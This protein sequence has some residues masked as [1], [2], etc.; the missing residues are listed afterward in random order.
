MAIHVCSQCGHREPI[1]GSDGG[2]TIASDYHTTLLGSLP[3][4]RS[5]REFADSGKPSVVADPDSNIAKYY[6]VIAQKMAAQLW[7]THSQAEAMLEI[8]VTDD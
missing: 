4:D 1:F 2:A 3:L 8:L 6:T 7:L 5:I